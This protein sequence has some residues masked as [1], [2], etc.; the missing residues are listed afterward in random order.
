MLIVI[1]LFIKVNFIGIYYCP[2][3]LYLLFNLSSWP[4][5]QVNIEKERKEKNIFY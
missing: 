2:A 3:V 4:L 1:A 5:L